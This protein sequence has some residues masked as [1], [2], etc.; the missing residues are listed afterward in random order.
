MR[1]LESTDPDALTRQ[2]GF[3]DATLFPE[4]GDMLVALNLEGSP[5]NSVQGQITASVGDDTL[6]FSGNLLATANGEIQGTGALEGRLTEAAGLAEVVGARGLSLPMANGRADLHFEGD[7]LMRLTGIRGAV[8]RYRIFG[9]I[10]AV[11]HGDDGGGGGR[12]GGRQHRCDGARRGGI[13]AGLADPRRRGVA[14]WTDRYRRYAAADAR[15][16]ER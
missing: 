15:L 8:G 6:S 4:Q 9:R 1:T 14:G 16:G 7:R 11:A 10:V 2:L 13:R 5:A 12:R 3:G